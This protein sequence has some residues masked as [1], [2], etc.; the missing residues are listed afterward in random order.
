MLNDIWGEH[1]VPTFS[2]CMNQ[3]TRLHGITLKKAVVLTV[4]ALE[5]AIHFL[6]FNMSLIG[7][8]TAVW[9]EPQIRVY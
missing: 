3:Q 8:V 1:I 9:T 6:Y 7:L 5:T 2:I 4:T